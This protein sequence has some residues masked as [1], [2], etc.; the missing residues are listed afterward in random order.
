MVL[1]TRN[2][3]GKK[4]SEYLVEAAHYYTRVGM[5]AVDRLNQI[6]KSAD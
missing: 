5:G 2:K 1:A 6:I 4:V 3:D